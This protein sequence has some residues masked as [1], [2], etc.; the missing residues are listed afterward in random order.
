M[1]VTAIGRSRVFVEIAVLPFNDRVR[2]GTQKDFFLLIE[3]F[4]ESFW[5]IVSKDS[6][7]GR[8][9]IS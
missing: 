9:A 7:F 4:E 1:L 2:A 3:A 5:Q 8:I 6:S